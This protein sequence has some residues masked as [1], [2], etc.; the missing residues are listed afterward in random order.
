[1]D[2]KTQGARPLHIILRFLQCCLLQ[3]SDSCHVFK[4]FRS[5]RRICNS[6][7]EPCDHHSQAVETA[8]NVASRASAVIG[9][10]GSLSTTFGGGFGMCGS[11]RKAISPPLRDFRY[12]HPRQAL[13]SLM[14]QVRRSSTPRA[15]GYLPPGSSRTSA[16]LEAPFV[17]FCCI[18]SLQ[19]TAW[20]SKGAPR[21]HGC[22][23]DLRD[24]KDP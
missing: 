13:D 2:T 11:S 24:P 5:S 6:M 20:G 18:L 21:T 19:G 22:P 17:H 14:M 10:S 1:M 9:W 4:S 3:G 8:E 12:I 23:K 7:Q 15:S 16:H